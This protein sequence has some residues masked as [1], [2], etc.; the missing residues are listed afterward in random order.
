[1]DNIRPSVPS[2]LEYSATKQAMYHDR[3]SRH[4]EFQAGENVWIKNEHE[5]GYYP[6]KVL[7][8]SGDLSYKIET[9]GVVKRKHA[10]QI[11][12]RIE[13]PGNEHTEM[14]DGT[15]S[16]N[17]APKTD[18]SLQ[19]DHSETESENADSKSPEN[20]Q[21]APRRSERIKNRMTKSLELSTNHKKKYKDGRM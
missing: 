13:P 16:Q 3:Q 4:R 15:Q 7:D 11:R 21:G 10:D 18:E 1:M 8:R 20:T 5:K 17:I 19:V 6:A 9:D 2:N 14:E 12:T